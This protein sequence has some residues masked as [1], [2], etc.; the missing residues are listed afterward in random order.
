MLK[1]NNNKVEQECQM[2]PKL[3]QVKLADNTIKIKDN[4]VMD[5][6]WAANMVVMVAN[7]SKEISTHFLT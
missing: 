2:M 3:D 4:T 5:K 1:D 6:A 7:V